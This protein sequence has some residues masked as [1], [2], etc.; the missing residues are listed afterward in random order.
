MENVVIEGSTVRIN[1]N[2]FEA[3]IADRDVKGFF[4]PNETRNDWTDTVRC[5]V[6]T[7]RC[8]MEIT[9]WEWYL[10]YDLKPTPKI[11]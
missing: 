8:P 4:P 9:Y 2:P 1:K 3:D 11:F 7:I 6:E 10:A 5:P